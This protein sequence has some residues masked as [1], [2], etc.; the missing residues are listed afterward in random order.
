MPESML[1]QTLDLV[2]RHPWWWA[3]TRLALSV[4]RQNQVRPPATVLDVGCGWGTNLDA[5]ELAGYRATGL[6]V[7]RQILNLI[8]RPERRL[9]EADLNQTLPAG[10]E[11]SDAALLLDVLEH[12]DD[13][14]SALRKVAQ[15]LKPGGLLVV[16]VPALP[17]LYSEFDRIQGH[18]RR[19]LPD[20]LRNAF[21]NTGLSVLDIFW[22]GAWMVPVLR[23]TRRKASQA[24][25]TAET[26]SRTYADYLRL[27]PWPVP[28]IMRWLYAWESKATLEGRLRAGTSLFALAVKPNN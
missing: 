22:W 14:Q 10:F 3:R 2:R 17:D 15:L 21:S 28:M 26:S 5:L 24:A 19:Y 8:D 20:S 7:S 9:V 4:L 25:E 1:V 11:P 16:T 12:L 6:D 18:R 23:R 13:D 27:P